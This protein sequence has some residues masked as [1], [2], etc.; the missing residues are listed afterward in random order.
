MIRWDPSV[1]LLIHRVNTPVHGML[2]VLILS[3]AGVHFKL[4]T[5]YRTAVRTES[6]CQP[7]WANGRL[8][9]SIK[10]PTPLA[11]VRAAGSRQV[12]G[13]ARVLAV[14]SRFGMPKG[15]GK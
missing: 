2:T 11:R 14:S 4:E 12:R 7:E 8:P 9:L 10:R 3:I 6:H 13:G 15:F 5:P 1:T